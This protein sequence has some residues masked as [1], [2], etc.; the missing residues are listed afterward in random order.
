MTRFWKSSISCPLPKMCSGSIPTATLQGFVQVAGK[1]GIEKSV[2][3][4]HICVCIYPNNF[5]WCYLGR[6]LGEVVFLLPQH[7]YLLPRFV[8][9]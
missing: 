8:P 7:A 9:F 5:E 6:S 4:I 1:V 2:L 3:L